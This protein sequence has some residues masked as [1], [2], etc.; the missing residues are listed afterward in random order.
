LMVEN[1]LVQFIATDAHDSKR[2]SP[3]FGKTEKW[4]KSK[5]G[6]AEADVYFRHNPSLILD[7]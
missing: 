5:Y 6:N 2:R 3:D 1:G 4:I 7:V